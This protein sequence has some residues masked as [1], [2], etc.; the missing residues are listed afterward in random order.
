MCI[1]SSTCYF[2]TDLSHLIDQK[3]SYQGIL[4]CS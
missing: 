2:S 3:Q 1:K 4:C